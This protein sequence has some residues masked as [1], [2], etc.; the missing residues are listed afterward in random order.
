MARKAHIT[1]VVLADGVAYRFAKLPVS[2]GLSMRFAGAMDG[3]EADRTE[4][5]RA[6]HTGFVSSLCIAGYAREEAERIT[7][8]ID[9]QDPEVVAALSA[10]VF[11]DLLQRGS[12]AVAAASDS[13]RP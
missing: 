3:Q 6:M 9:L 8:L 1:E 2:T 10:A 11:P 7:W 4:A 5:M 13:V 12:E